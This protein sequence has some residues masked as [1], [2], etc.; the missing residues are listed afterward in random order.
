MHFVGLGHSHIVALAKGA[1]S[2]IAKGVDLAEPTTCT[3]HYLYDDPFDPP[4]EAGGAMNPNI[5]RAASEGAPRFILA[6]MGGNEHNVLSVQQASP[7]FDFVLGENPGLPLDRSAEILTESLVRETLRSW[8]REKTDVLGA[9]RAATAL[10]IYQVEPPPPLPR[11]HVLAYPKELFR[12][13]VDRRTMAPD[14]LRYKMWR[15]QCS[16]YREICADCGV[17]YVATPPQTID[18]TGMLAGPWCG[19]DATH[20]NEAFGELM[21]REV[22]DRYMSEKAGSNG[23]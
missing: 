6:S 21:V 17:E 22:L 2:L 15:A 23:T 10:P 8:M 20:A 9:L 7:R 3:F 19:P 16:V 14:I 1:Y 12:S 11:A 4:F 18:G 5:L 13:I